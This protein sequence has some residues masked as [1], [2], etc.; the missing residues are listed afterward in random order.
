MH[1]PT[2]AD[3]LYVFETEMAAMR[4]EG[5]RFDKAALLRWRGWLSRVAIDKDI[6]TARRLA[7]DISKHVAAK[8]LAR[9]AKDAGSNGR[10][11]RVI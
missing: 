7:A 1:K 11:E 6:K 10:R 9:I 5:L 2:V 8:R 3:C 4:N